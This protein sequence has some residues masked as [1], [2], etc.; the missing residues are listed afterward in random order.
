MRHQ[1]AKGARITRPPRRSTARILVC[2]RG[3]GRDDGG[4]DADAARAEGDALRHVA[5]RRGEHAALE[6]LA[7]SARHDVGGAADFEGADRLQV[8]E[9]QVDV[10]GR[11]GVCSGTSG[12]RRATPAM[13]PRASSTWARVIG[14]FLLCTKEHERAGS[15]KR[16]LTVAA[17]M[18]RPA[19]VKREP[20]FGGLRG[21]APW[22]SMR[23]RLM[24]RQARR[25]SG[26]SATRAD[27]REAVCRRV[28]R[29]PFPSSQV[30]FFA[31]GGESVKGARFVRGLRTLDRFAPLPYN[32]CSRERGPGVSG[33]LPPGGV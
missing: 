14:I 33:G 19:P 7:R 21:L 22:R 24:A 26:W 13:L 10:G 15:L 30:T 16:S 20:N 32:R 1:S 28:P 23:Q 12:V 17:S 8:L 11:V 31:S 6:P 3:I 4:G 18:R 9:L 5:G 29:A 27:R 2:G 25:A